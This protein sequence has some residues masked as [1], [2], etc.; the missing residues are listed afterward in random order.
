MMII[1]RTPTRGY[2]LRILRA[3]GT[4]GIDG[5]PPPRPKPEVRVERPI[6]TQPS[7]NHT[8]LSPR[9]LVLIRITS[10]KG[11]TKIFPSPMLPDFAA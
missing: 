7:V 5:Q 3:D 10:D 2:R 6:S 11:L 8:A 9:S 4:L 1:V